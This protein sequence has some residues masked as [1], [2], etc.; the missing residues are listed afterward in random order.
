MVLVVIANYVSLVR[1]V[2]GHLG[3]LNHRAGPGP[4]N[5]ITFDDALS[6]QN[7]VN[8]RLHVQRTVGRLRAVQRI[9]FVVIV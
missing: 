7:A 9:R 3:W 1:C 8:R 5:K 6:P 4:G 2:V